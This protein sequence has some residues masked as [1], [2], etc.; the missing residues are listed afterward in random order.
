MGPLSIDLRQAQCTREH[1]AR[2]SL[3]QWS[4][5][6]RPGA[7]QRTLLATAHNL[8]PEL[9]YGARG[10]S[11]Y[12]SPLK[13]GSPAPLRLHNPLP[14]LFLLLALVLA[15][16]AGFVPRD[17]LTTLRLAALMYNLKQP[18]VGPFFGKCRKKG[19]L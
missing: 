2:Y 13:A 7:L 14:M 17:F 11:Y 12:Y 9:R 1:S 5:R 8:A 15:L 19:A 4:D 16:P 10:V 18:P 6:T 3:A